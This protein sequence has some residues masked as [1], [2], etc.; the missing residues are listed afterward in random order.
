MFM[1]LQA[2]TTACKQ[3]SKIKQDKMY[4]KDANEDLFIFNP[5]NILHW[6]VKCETHTLQSTPEPNN[7]S[8]LYLIYNDKEK[9]HQTLT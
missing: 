5:I 6:S 1:E 7:N 2:V 4:C 9:R 3:K 8:K